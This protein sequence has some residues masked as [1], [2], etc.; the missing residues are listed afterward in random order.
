MG[1]KGK[2]Y[3][4]CGLTKDEHFGIHF[5]PFGHVFTVDKTKSMKNEKLKKQEATA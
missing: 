1:M 5:S 2:R 4:E 3:T